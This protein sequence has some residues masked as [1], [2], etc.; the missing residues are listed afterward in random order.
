LMRTVAAW[1]SVC[2]ASNVAAMFEI[3]E[4]TVSSGVGP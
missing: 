4:S 3:G 2:P 1:A